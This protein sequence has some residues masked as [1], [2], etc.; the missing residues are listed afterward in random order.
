MVRARIALS[1]VLGIVLVAAFFA[2]PAADPP[3]EYLVVAEQNQNATAPTAYED[4]A[5]GDR[6]AFDAALANGGVV[7][8]VGQTYAD[9]I[10][11]PDGNT[12]RAAEMQV[13]HESTRYDLRRVYEPTFPDTVGVLRTLGALV[14]GVA[15]LA[16][17]GYRATTA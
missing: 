13:E 6:A 14:G 10:E 9:S 2:A 12:K 3:D 1:A 16:Y 8:Y 5:V 4:L 11:F 15:A 7:R 17:A